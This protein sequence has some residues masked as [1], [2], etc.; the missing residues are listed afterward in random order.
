M[1][2]KFYYLRGLRMAFS[3]RECGLIRA[4]FCDLPIKRSFTDAFERMYT[5][6]MQGFTPR[7]EPHYAKTVFVESER[8]SSL[9]AI[10]WLEIS[11][12]QDGTFFSLDNLPANT[13]PCTI[14]VL[15]LAAKHY[16]EAINSS[17]PH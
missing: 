6:D 10:H 4:L 11:Q 9:S 1:N 17:Q 2:R 7:G 13:V 3:G 8:G 12:C 14:D 15:H 5:E 16:G